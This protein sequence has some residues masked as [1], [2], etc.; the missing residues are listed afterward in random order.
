MLLNGYERGYTDFPIQIGLTKKKMEQEYGSEEDW[1]AACVRWI[2]TW[3]NQYSP[4]RDNYDKTRTVFTNNNTMMGEADQIVENFLFYQGDQPLREYYYFIQ[5]PNPN[6]DIIAQ[7]QGTAPSAIIPTPWIK[8]HKIY[9]LI[10]YMQ[11]TFAGRVAAARLSVENMSKDVRTMKHR[12]ITKAIL[13]YEYAELLKSFAEQTGVEFEPFPSQQFDKVDDAIN[14][15]A[16]TPQEWTEREALRILG[17][18]ESRNETKGLMEKIFKNVIIGR[19]GGCYI[20][21]DGNGRLQ[22][23]NVAPQN[24]ILDRRVDHDFH[25]KD[26]FVGFIQFMTPEEVIVKY[27]NLSEED[28]E[29]IIRTARS[30]PEN[31][32]KWNVNSNRNF[33]WWDY[34]ADC[35]IA[36][37]SCFWRSYKDGKMYKDG[38]RWRYLNPNQKNRKGDFEVETIRKATLIGNKYL[39]DYGEDECII[40]DPKDPSRVMLPILWVAPATHMGYNKSLVDRLKALQNNIDAIENKINDSISHDFG[41]VYIFDGSRIKGQAPDEILSDI[42]KHR[43]SIIS[44]RDGEELRPDE[45][46]PLVERMD[47]SISQNVFRYVELQR[48]KERLM[49]EIAS[50]SKIALGQQQTYVGLSTQQNT[51][52]QNTR[53]SEH[54]YSAVLKLY[55]DIMAYSMEKIKLGYLHN[56]N[57]HVLEEITDERGINFL[58]ETKDLSFADL[59][60]KVHIEDIVDDQMKSALIQAAFAALQNQIIDFLDYVKL[61]QMKTYTEMS[62]YFEA[63]IS[64]KQ[65]AKDREALLNEIMSIAKI[66]AQGQQIQEQQAI[67]EQ[68][69]M[70]RKL[71]DAGVKGA[72]MQQQAMMQ[73]QGQQM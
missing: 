66:N 55:S 65:N 56:K 12:L 31:L 8:G 40:Y 32:W 70:E 51:I 4:L 63:V 25:G 58:N 36:V 33:N 19:Y 60:V 54:I 26:E 45:M 21:L 46:G 2:T 13:R 48:E 35:K 44:R 68:G 39:T 64:R 20:Y 61:I 62:T 22:Q 23:M 49:E 10:S 73:Q 72:E 14:F 30:Q 16:K 28:R 18:I 34:Q 53:G 7:S 9:Q 11:G 42:K 57:R 71:V 29:D 41:N 50:T 43:L 47:M 67:K 59:M 52:A 17:N 1:Y 3:Y 6:L 15:I 37:V 24:L 69:A 38:S 5:D 27:P